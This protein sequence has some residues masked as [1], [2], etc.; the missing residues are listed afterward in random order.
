MKIWFAA[1]L[2]G[3]CPFVRA[4]VIATVTA[5]DLNM[6]L[7]PS[8][9]YFDTT[10]AYSLTA[11]DNSTDWAVSAVLSVNVNVDNTLPSP[12]EVDLD[13]ISMTCI[14]VSGC[15]D[16]GEVEFSVYLA[17]DNELELPGEYDISFSGSSTAGDPDMGFQLDSVSLF[18]TQ[19]VSP[20]SDQY[21]FSDS[22][23]H[24]GDQVPY[25]SESGNVVVG[26]ASSAYGTTFTGSLDAAFTPVPVPE[27]ASAAVSGL[28][29]VAMAVL[30]W[31]RK[32]AARS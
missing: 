28:L 12:I 21:S 5:S 22:G 31:R 25:F 6:T 26:D 14:D 27:P 8:A 29:A 20:V 2:L 16:S 24:V 10:G 15:S 9:N 1:A 11:S 3:I 32:Q 4:E 30:A 18:L 13:N 19:F 17:L 23:D 7:D